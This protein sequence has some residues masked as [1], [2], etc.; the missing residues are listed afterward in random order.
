MAQARQLFSIVRGLLAKINPSSGKR[1]ST[2]TAKDAPAEE[3][4]AKDPED[5]TGVSVQ[6]PD[7]FKDIMAGEFVVN[8]TYEKVKAE[9][10]VWIAEYVD[11]R[12]CRTSLPL[13]GTPFVSIP[14]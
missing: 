10:D 12:V 5:F 14:N 1:A 9:A 8:P 3:K 7:L 6:L 2:I 11:A 4:P 13:G